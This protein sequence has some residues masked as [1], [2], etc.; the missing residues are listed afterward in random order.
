MINEYIYELL[1]RE[2]NLVKHEL[3][4]CAS[5]TDEQRSFIFN[6]KDVYENSDKLLVLIHGSG[7]VRAGQ[8]ARR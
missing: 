1:E 7:V 6:S 4:G 3:N 8:W 5:D 2:G